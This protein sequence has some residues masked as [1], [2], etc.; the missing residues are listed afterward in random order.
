MKDRRMQTVGQVNP[1]M[2]PIMWQNG[3]FFTAHYFHDQYRHGLEERGEHGKHR[4]LKNFVRVIRMMPVY[5]K[6][7][8]SQDIVVLEWEA[9]KSIKSE[10]IPNLVQLKHLFQA[11]GY[12][13]IMLLNATAQLE[14]THHLDDELSKE[15]AYR[16]SKSTA[17][18][19]LGYGAQRREVADGLR[20]E[21]D[22]M[23]IFGHSPQQ[24]L[25][26]AAFLVQKNMG[27]DME[28][29]LK[30]APALLLAPNEPNWMG[31][32][33]ITEAFGLKRGDF[34][35]AMVE[36]GYA[37]R[38]DNR[39]RYL[40]I[41]TKAKDAGVGRVQRTTSKNGGN[42][43]VDQVQWTEEFAKEMVAR[44]KKESAA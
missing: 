8:E 19:Q 23:Q 3:E 13:P 9:V 42:T 16:H 18:A 25:I 11:S 31:V 22:L 12:Q 1:L 43:I 10:A 6:L 24:A 14:L 28:P 38:T 15:I 4:Q 33:D 37:V 36:Y 35:E 2:Q 30:N 34:T 41:T 17:Q 21:I 26:Q 29:Y 5:N 32:E 39:K 7:I 20:A 27:V 44:M 40:D